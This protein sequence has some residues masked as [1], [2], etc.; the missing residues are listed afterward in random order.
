MAVG[1]EKWTEEQSNLF[2]ELRNKI[3]WSLGTT[4]GKRYSSASG[5]ETQALRSLAGKLAGGA[6]I[7]E[8]IASDWPGRIPI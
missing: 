1:G 6:L 8:G 3:A 4:L 2:K 7:A 5:A